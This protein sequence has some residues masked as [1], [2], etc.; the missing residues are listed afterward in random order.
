MKTLHSR[1]WQTLLAFCACTLSLTVPSF[2]AN[3]GNGNGNSKGHKAEGAVFV[4]SNDAEK[5]EIVA[6]NRQDDGTLTFDNR[7]S[8]RGSGQG[9]DFDTQGG[10]TLSSDHRFLYACNPGTDDVAVFSVEGS[11]LKFLQLVEAGDQPLSITLSGNLAYVLDGSVAG[12]GI[13]GFTVSADGKLTPI[14]NSFRALSSPI[15]VPGEVRFSPDGRFL[16][17]TH[18]VGSMIDVFQVGSTGLAGNPTPYPSAGPRPFAVAFRNDGKLL[19]VESGLPTP[20]N[21]GVSSY[22]MNAG[23]GALSVVTA[24]AKNMQTDGC[25]IVI[26]GDQRYAYTAN[27]V[28]GTISSYLLGAGGTVTLINGA[29]ASSGA[30]SNVTDLGFSADSRYLYNLLRGAGG[31]A[32]YRVEPDG[33]LTPLGVVYDKSLIPTNGPSG[34]ASY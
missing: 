16:V 2:G 24:S 10:L 27:F 29:A 4:M 1:T 31:V 25:W 5:N 7:Y 14:P 9:V 20:A 18:K 32:A 23:S 34:L 13:T 21:A 8:S 15:A 6:F 11:K 19:V 30:T 3:N 22:D 17:V 33:G 26:T 12:N 28:N